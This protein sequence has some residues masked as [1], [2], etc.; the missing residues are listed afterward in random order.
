[1]KTYWK[2]LLLVVA[3]AIMNLEA[4]TNFNLRA[5][6]FDP[7]SYPV[8]FLTIDWDGPCGT[9]TVKTNADL[10]TNWSTYTTKV[11]SDLPWQRDL[12]VDIPIDT[13]APGAVFVQ[14]SGVFDTNQTNCVATELRMRLNP[15]DT[16]AYTNYPARFEGYAVGPNDKT[17]QW[18]FDDASLSGET[19]HVLV[20]SNAVPSDGGDYYL[21]AS[22]GYQNRTSTVAVLTVTN[23]VPTFE[24]PPSPPPSPSGGGGESM[25]SLAMDFLL[26]YNDPFAE[27]N[28]IIH[29]RLRKI[30][31]SLEK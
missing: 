26:W 28:P 5:Y 11:K 31:E 19:N 3:L 4:A 17:Y 24:D 7:P 1:M 18:Y 23:A 10:G 30:E 25:E 20:I 12:Y 29:Q 8:S 14:V 27:I 21:V 6:Y 22:A 13:N 16:T 15:Q 2:P 9:Y